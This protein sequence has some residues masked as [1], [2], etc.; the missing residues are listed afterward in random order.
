[1]LGAVTLT[2]LA[3]GVAGRADVVTVSDGVAESRAGRTVG[4]R[5]QACGAEGV[6]LYAFAGREEVAI[7]TFAARGGRSALDAR[8]RA[9]VALAA[10][11]VPSSFAVGAHL[12]VVGLACVTGRVASAAL[13]VLESQRSIAVGTLG[14]RVVA[15][16]AV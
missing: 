14:G 2:A 12:V 6:T 10:G 15:G 4:C 3:A 13:F 7:C 5:G 9:E 8:R 1:M 16:L 11:E